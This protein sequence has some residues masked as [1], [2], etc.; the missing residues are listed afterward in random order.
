MWRVK[1]SGL[2]AGF[3]VTCA[4]YYKLFALTL[5]DDGEAQNRKYE[6]IEG[7]LSC[8]ANEAMA[9]AP[10]ELNAAL[11]KDNAPA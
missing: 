7:K 3:T 9:A 5:I 6:L 8:A 4:L 10:A 11:R 1:S 2:I